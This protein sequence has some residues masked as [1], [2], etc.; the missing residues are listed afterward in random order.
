MVTPLSFALP[1]V[2]IPFQKADPSPEGDCV[3]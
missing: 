1:D 2:I 3:P